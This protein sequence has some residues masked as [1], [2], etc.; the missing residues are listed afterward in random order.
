LFIVYKL[1]TKVVVGRLNLMR[2][3]G[4][5]YSILVMRFWFETAETKNRTHLLTPSI[6][7]VRE[8]TWRAFG[9]E[10]HREERATLLARAAST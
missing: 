8:T 5:H 4:Y 2:A 6:E 3:G 9:E 10:N 7:I 1:V